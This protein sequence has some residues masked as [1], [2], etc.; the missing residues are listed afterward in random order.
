MFGKSKR[1]SA[2]ARFGGSHDS[3]WLR[4]SAGPGMP[5]HAMESKV[6]V[7]VMPDGQPE[8]ASEIRAWGKDVDRIRPGDQTYVLYDPEDPGHCEIDHDRLR[9]EFGTGNNGKDLVAI[10]TRGTSDRRAAYLGA[11][12][13][14]GASATP[15]D[16]RTA[17]IEA[18]GG[19][20]AAPAPATADVAA[21]LAKLGELHANGTLTD[22]EF[23]QA[24]AQLLSS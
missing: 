3:K 19:R 1:T 2:L 5:S 10:P 16:R 11:M 23:A 8:F 14:M 7:H 21:S 15:E 18:M 12:E 17:L 22:A 4:G 9:K 6:Q 20:A 24:K 13:S